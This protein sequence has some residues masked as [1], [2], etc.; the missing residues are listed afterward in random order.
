M[1]GTQVSP[2]SFFASEEVTSLVWLCWISRTPTYTLSSF[3][4][5]YMF[6]TIYNRQ[7][8]LIHL[9]GPVPFARQLIE[10]TGPA[11]QP[12]EKKKSGEWNRGPFSRQ[13]IRIWACQPINPRLS[14]SFSNSASCV[15]LPFGSHN[16]RPKTQNKAYLASIFLPPFDLR[17]IKQ[18]H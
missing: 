18:S 16:T 12:K 7:P 13:E 4:F 5:I 10:R 2:Q 11:H 6:Q 17:L 15:S 1:D 9:M 8:G 14:T 3:R